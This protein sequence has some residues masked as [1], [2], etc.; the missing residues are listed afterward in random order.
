MRAQISIK[1]PCC[2]I[3]TTIL[4]DLQGIEVRLDS[5]I[6]FALIRFVHSILALFFSEIE[7]FVLCS[8]VLLMVTLVLRVVFTTP[9]SALYKM[10]KLTSNIVVMVL[11]QSVI[12]LMTQNK[13]ILKLRDT[14]LGLLLESFVATTC[15]LVLLSLFTHIFHDVDAVQRS[16]NLLLFIY[17]D[18]TE[19][20]IG[21]LKID[22]LSS[23][24]LSVLVYTF[25]IVYTNSQHTQFSLVYLL[26]GLNMVCM[27]V[28][29]RS[30]VQLDV[31]YLGLEKQA[32]VLVLVLFLID[33]FT[34]LVPKLNEAR[35]YAIWKGSQKLFLVITYLELPP[36]T[37]LFVTIALLYSK[38]LW[39][40]MLTAVYELALLVILNII[41]DLA[42]EYIATAYTVDKAI[43]LFTYVMII[44]TVSGLVFMSK[45]KKNG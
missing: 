35:D 25:F 5:V 44:Q 15:L 7:I 1:P 40:K 9:K 4:E 22:A 34:Q 43:L 31:E 29:L 2:P 26:R 27:N 18:A 36:D 41:L 45:N 3:M 39:N 28:I 32:F 11:S 30:F 8:I 14:H 42:S 16:M 10:L 37:I 12:N 19:F 13:R 38:P 24:S 20:V 6:T 21:A 23:L 33:S 17:A